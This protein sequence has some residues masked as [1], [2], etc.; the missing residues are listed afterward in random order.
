MRLRQVFAGIAVAG[1][2]TAGLIGLGP[3]SGAGANPAPGI[4]PDFVLEPDGPM[5][6][7]EIKS[8]TIGA[9]R[10][11]SPENCRNHAVFKNVCD[12]YRLKLNL[13]T[14]PGAQNFV[15]I[16]LEYAQTTA[17]TL[18]LPLVAVTPG[19][20]PELDLVLYRTATISMAPAL[21]GGQDLNV[22]ERVAFI[23][24]QSEYDIVVK[25]DQGVSEGYTLRMF[26]SDEIFDSQFEL[27]EEVRKRIE[28]TPAPP[29]APPA[30]DFTPPP[31]PSEE[32]VFADPNAL[33]PLRPI[34]NL[35]LDSRINGI[36]LGTTT[37]FDF[38]PQV[39]G[40]R[41]QRAV[42]VADA[43]SGVSLLLGLLVLPLVAAAGGAVWLRRRRQALI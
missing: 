36:G 1:L 16:F 18:S 17:P 30:E 6:T 11:E 2:S 34:D 12:A 3:T 27:L 9:P 43:P 24:N 13:S 40:Q 31:S 42:A 38:G 39:L 26:M 7:R 15:V 5:I 20:V 29:A 32:A 8:T 10:N 19:G 21:V 22:P 25:N 4:P 35:R 37:N 33:P 28:E 41:T 14:K 23:A